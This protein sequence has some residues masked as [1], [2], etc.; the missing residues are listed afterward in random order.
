VTRAASAGTR[1][2]AALLSIVLA[3]GCATL[4]PDKGLPVTGRTITLRAEPNGQKI[5]G[6]LLVVEKDRVYVR[7]QDRVHEVPIGAVREAKVKRHDFG[8]KRTLVVTAV[9]GLV[10]GVAIAAACASVEDTSGCG[11]VAPV[12]LALW[13]AV[14]AA[15]APSMESSS[16][17]KLEKPSPAEL[18][19]FARLPQG[20]PSGV[21]VDALKPATH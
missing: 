7:A 11:N 20:L 9:V 15:C 5:Q 13:M 12:T 16:R 14:G 3:P 19:S 17:I 8:A 21:K 2:L 4:S 1:L 6:E 10:T 18:R